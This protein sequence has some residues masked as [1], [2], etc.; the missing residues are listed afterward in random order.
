MRVSAK[1]SIAHLVRAIETGETSVA[2]TA[3]SAGS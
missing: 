1:A 3:F 2:S